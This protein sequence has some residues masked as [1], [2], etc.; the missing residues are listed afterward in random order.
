MVSLGL[1]DLSCEVRDGLCQDILCLIQWVGVRHG[2]GPPG[3]RDR[4]ETEKKGGRPRIA[5]WEGIGC[6]NDYWT[7][8]RDVRN[9]CGMGSTGLVRWRCIYRGSLVATRC[10]KGVSGRGER[11]YPGDDGAGARSNG[12]E[13]GADGGENIGLAWKLLPVTWNPV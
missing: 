2:V 9:P 7:L 6:I 3:A 10:R 8:H 1:V 4:V 12:G 11:S 5:P 13:D